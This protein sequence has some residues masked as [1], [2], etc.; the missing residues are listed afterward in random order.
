MS[1]VAKSVQLNNTDCAE[2][3]GHESEAY[4]LV[5]QVAKMSSQVIGLIEQ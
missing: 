5:V 4:K 3:S 1:V 2:E